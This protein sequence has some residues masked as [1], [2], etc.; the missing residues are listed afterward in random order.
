MQIFFILPL[1]EILI[2]IYCFGMD[3]FL[4]NLLF[5]KDKQ[6]KNYSEI[7]IYGFLLTLIF[8]QIINLITPIRE[9]YFW[10]F[11]TLSIINIYKNKFLTKSFLNW[12]FKIF[13]IFLILT[14]FKFVIK[15]HD[16]L[17]YHLA[18]LNIIESHKIIFG[19][20]NF[21]ESF[22]FTNGWS[23]VG[24]FFNFFLDLKKIYI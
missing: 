19:I 20:A 15:G 17:Y 14:P 12:L 2:V 8:A 11:L 10:I 3:L 13:I 9:I 21:Y 4:N 7:C 1:T 24:G 16:D 5:F 18:K 22:A 23:H 6:L